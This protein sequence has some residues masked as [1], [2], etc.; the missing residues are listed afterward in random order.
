MSPETASFPIQVTPEF[1]I[2]AEAVGIAMAA[3]IGV[4][5]ILSRKFNIG[6]LRI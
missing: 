4:T 6:G 1:P 5:V 3:F 2:G